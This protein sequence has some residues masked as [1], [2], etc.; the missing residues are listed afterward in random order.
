MYTSLEN[1]K[2]Y[3]KLEIT[4]KDFADIINMIS[5]TEITPED[6]SIRDIPVSTYTDEQGNNKTRILKLDY[7]NDKKYTFVDR[8]IVKK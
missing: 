2:D 3:R 8:K 1:K 6:D 4:P 7:T 5:V